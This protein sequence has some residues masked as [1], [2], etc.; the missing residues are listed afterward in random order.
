MADTDLEQPV[1][2]L[3]Q[4]V[5]RILAL[6]ID[7]G[8]VCA[9]LLEAVG[10]QHRLI[11]WLGEP[12]AADAPLP[13]ALGAACR[14]LGEQLHCRLWDADAHTPF[15]DSGDPI[16]HPP[17]DHVC[18]AASPLL[19]LR[20]WLVGLTGSVGVAAA[21]HAL[22][23]C[24]VSIVGVTTLTRDL[25]GARLA[26]E[27][28]LA[29]PQVLVLIGGFDVEDAGAQAAVLGLVT[30]ALASVERLPAEQQPE[31]LFAGNR[32]V[33]EQLRLRAAC[34]IVDN[35]LPQP[36]FVRQEALIATL[37][38][39]YWAACRRVPQFSQVLD[40]ATDP[41]ATTTLEVNFARLVRG[42]QAVH[43]LP[44]L[45][46]L[47]DALDRRLHVWAQRDDMTLRVL[48]LQ[49]QQPAPAGWPGV[50]LVSSARRMPEPSHTSGV[51][52]D[53]AGLAP[54]IA[55]AGHSAPLAMLQVLNQDIFDR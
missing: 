18:I 35:I 7:P 22:A 38:E 19:P 28:A 16:R 14:R 40:W 39:R 30:T 15:R 47:Y 20:V 37:H 5:G 13:E 53:S 11:G 52:R 9:C 46:G 23:A 43:A 10:G 34:L 54:V 51:W 49:P 2:N 1:L 25:D 4:G 32:W 27:L 45:H 24:P 50:G 29:R 17:I 42:W 55:A 3:T 12:W 26:A 6:G 31:L 8:S 44:E 48:Y 36:G 41:V 33:A 21:Q